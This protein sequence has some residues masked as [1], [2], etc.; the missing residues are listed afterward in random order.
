MINPFRLRPFNATTDQDY[1]H[2]NTRGFGCQSPIGRKGGPQVI[3]AHDCIN[4][5]GSWGRVCHEVMHSIGLYLNF[6]FYTSILTIINH[7]NKQLKS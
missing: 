2:I 7:Y 6:Y 1:I 5:G 4:N 3:R